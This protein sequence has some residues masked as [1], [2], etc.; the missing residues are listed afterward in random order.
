MIPSLCRLASNRLPP[1]IYHY[2]PTPITYSRA[3]LLQETILSR[4]IAARHA[5]ATANSPS[6][7][8]S[9]TSP[10]LFESHSATTLDA[11]ELTAATDVL[12]LLQHQP[13]YT[14]GRRMK[15]LKSTVEEGE[16]LVRESGAEYEV[17]LRGGETTFHGI[18]QMVGYCSMDLA[19]A[20]V[21]CH[22]LDSS[23]PLPLFC[24]ILRRSLPRS[25]P[26]GQI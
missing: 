17:C 11:L 14:A 13:V 18:G 20:G 15:D 12:L 9:T 24:L 6:S 22:P 1:L 5:L 25:H 3:L 23:N 4:R 26:A 21:R 10:S 2:L 8:I 7:I 16:R 19:R